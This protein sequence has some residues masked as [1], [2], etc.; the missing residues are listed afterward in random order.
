MTDQ[1][2]NNVIDKSEDNLAHNKN[3]ASF[4]QRLMKAQFLRYT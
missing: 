1:I 2:E 3:E 4:S